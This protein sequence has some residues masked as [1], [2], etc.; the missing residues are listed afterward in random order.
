MLKLSG[1]A[2]R[3]LNAD[4]TRSNPIHTLK[5]EAPVSKLYEGERKNV[6]LQQPTNQDK[7]VFVL[8]C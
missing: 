8:A 4:S 5:A 3:K 7:G 1:Q 6:D 2:Q